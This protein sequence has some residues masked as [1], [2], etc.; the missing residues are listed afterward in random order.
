LPDIAND[1]AARVLEYRTIKF[2]REAWEQVNNAESFEGW[3]RIGAALAIGKQHALGT[4]GANAPWGQYY[5][6]Q[7]SK[8]AKE[9]GFSTMRPSDRSYAI[10]LHET[11]G[12]L[13]LGG[14]VYQIENVAASPPLNPTS[15]D[16][17]SRTTITTAT[18]NALTIF[19]AML[20][21]LCGVL[22]HARD[23]CQRAKRCR[24]GRPCCPKRA[25]SPTSLQTPRLATQSILFLSRE[26]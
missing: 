10:A 26:I 7:F 25:H 4:S 1:T 13:L 6:R 18:A 3:R 23:R 11:S 14:P 19:D 17:A 2:G 15:S 12:R 22:F 9:M 5:C 8:W 24:C 20:W 21:P 16:G